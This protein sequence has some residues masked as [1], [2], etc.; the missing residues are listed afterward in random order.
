MACDSNGD[1]GPLLVE[2]T[3]FGAIFN[4][5]CLADGDGE[6]ECLPTVLIEQ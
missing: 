4:V 2:T 6:K 3:V 1:L 5:V